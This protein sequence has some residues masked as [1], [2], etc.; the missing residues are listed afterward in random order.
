ME[1]GAAHVESIVVAI[2]AAALFFDTP[3][4]QDGAGARW[5]E[6]GGQG[7]VETGCGRAEVVRC[8]DGARPCRRRRARACGREG[9]R[10]RGHLSALRRS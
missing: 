5:T 6:C 2:W 1:Q 10:R 7:N 4:E 8:R 3:A 9:E